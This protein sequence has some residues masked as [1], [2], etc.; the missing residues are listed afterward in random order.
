MLQGHE[1]V[2]DASR[3]HARG[4]VDQLPPLAERL[5]VVAAVLERATQVDA[6]WTELRVDA[7]TFLQRVDRASQVAGLAQSD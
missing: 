7:D 2:A 1:L 6:A 4:G 5:S 3:R